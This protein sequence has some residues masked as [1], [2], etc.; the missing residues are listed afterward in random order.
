[1]R[2][3]FVLIIAVIIALVVFTFYFERSLLTILSNNHLLP[4]PETFTEL[5]FENHENLPSKVE[6]GETYTFA[7]SVHSE[8]YRNMTFP[9]AIYIQTDK[10]RIPITKGQFSLMQN[11]NKTFNEKFTAPALTDGAEVVVNLEN[12][13]QDIDFWIDE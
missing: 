8:E 10:K 9:Y 2:Y 12:K 4:E 6:A 7:F 11:Q 1:M 3:T 13:N 5:Y